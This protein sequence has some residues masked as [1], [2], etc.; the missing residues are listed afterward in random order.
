MQDL[1]GELKEFQRKHD[2]RF[3]S[4]VFGPE[5]DS[6]IRA[7]EKMVGKKENGLI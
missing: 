5:R 7:I 6:W 3:S 1:T 4:E 2:Y